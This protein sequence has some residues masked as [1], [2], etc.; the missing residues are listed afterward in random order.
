MTKNGNSGRSALRARSAPPRLRGRLSGQQG[1]TLME[2]MVVTS[3][4]A[5]LAAIAIPQFSA[6]ALQMRTNAAASE[7]LDDI[8]FARVMSQRTGVPHYITPNF[9]G[10][11]GV[12]YNEMVLAIADGN[13][14]L[15]DAYVVLLFKAALEKLKCLREAA[16]KNDTMDESMVLE[17]IDRPEWIGDEQ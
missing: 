2:M 10:G 4:I 11:T 1:W 3:L 12:S 5:I 14:L 7:L 6:M 15:D 8:Q 16:I 17:I 9:A 13:V